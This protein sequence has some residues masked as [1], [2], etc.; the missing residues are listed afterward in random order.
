M[1]IHQLAAVFLFI[2]L[3]VTGKDALTPETLWKFGRVGEVTLS[4][5]GDRVAYT[6]RTY[7]IAA[8]KGNLDLWVTDLATGKAL[9]LCG[10]AANETNPVWSSDGNSV[11]F[12]SDAGG[13]SQIWRVASDGSGKR[14]LTR[15]EGGVNAFGIAASGKRLWYAQ[16]VKVT[17]TLGAD[18]Y[19][20]LPKNTARIY[21]DL[22]MRHWDRWDDG[23]FSHVFTAA[24][25]DTGIGVPVDLMPGEPYDAPMKPFG[26]AEEVAISPDGNRI[27]YTCKKLFGKAY[28]TSTN[29][30]IY[31]YDVV[32]GKTTNLTEGNKGYDRVPEFSPDG[33]R[34]AWQSLEEDGNEADQP[35]LFV[36]DLTTNVRR[37]LT[38]GFV[39]NVEAHHWSPSGQQL[40]FLAGI[41]ATIQVFVADLRTRSAMAWRQLSNDI[42]DHTSFS[43][44]RNA[45]KEEVI[46]TTREDLSHPAELYV[47]DTK[48]A[49]S[50]QL[51]QV[52]IG[53]LDQLKMGEVCKRMV[54]TTD[55]K[56]MLTWVIYPPDF[57]SAKKYPTLLYCQGGPQ[58]ML[59]QFF[60]YRWNLQLM[61]ANGYIVVAPNRRGMPGFGRA[62]NDDISGDWGGQP[63][64]DLLSAIDDVSKEA[65]VD[66]DKLGAV[67]ASY[68]GYSVYWLAGNHEKRFKCFIAHNGVFNL[69]S[70]AATE[71]LFFSLHEMQG[72]YWDVP[73][74]K[75]FER[76]SPHR[77][78]QHW[79]TPIL[80][81][82]NELDYRIPYSQGLEAFTAARLR[83]IPARFLSYP[84]ENHWVL[85]PQNSI[86]WQRVFFDWLDR[87][88]K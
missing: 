76:Y 46:V 24:L 41:D 87:Y 9:L 22:M 44:A 77:F 13:S 52:N 61:A 82:A 43:I 59:G 72:S 38:E 10:E 26:G 84:D 36:L 35:R 48:T 19:P 21:D 28:A 3:I 18:I 47:F 50:R 11:N 33:N 86:V 6:V 60:S 64:R 80:I 66:K 42:A 40:Y 62:W 63:M 56:E 70:A 55:N 32:T 71:E 39:H 27:A 57:D 78:V 75:S 30:E 68:G 81:I 5:R 69:E 14:Q 20:D 23:T 1:K 74:P 7:D 53:V 88:L 29:S 25:T 8:G 85:R 58:S 51:S 37:N 31:L 49:K 79:D 16:D 34:L 83:D 15:L 54:R 4:P 73:V 67:G 2:P 45:K 17:K 12:L 65:Y